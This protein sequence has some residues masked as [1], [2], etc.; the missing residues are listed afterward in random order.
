MENDREKENA[1]MLQIIKY[2]IDKG[3]LQEESSVEFV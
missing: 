3:K 2:L 1:L